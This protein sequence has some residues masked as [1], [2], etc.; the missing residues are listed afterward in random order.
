MTL[1][2]GLPDRQQI[3][4]LSART[5]LEI[6]AVLFN[7]DEPFTFTSG[8]KSPVYIDCR[9]IIAFPR[10]RRLL[11]D[12]AL[13]NLVREIGVESIDCIAGGETAGIPF[14][15][16]LADRLDLPMCYVRKEPKG[17]G[18][19]AQIEGDLAEGARTLLVE[20]LTTDG[21]SKVRFVEALRKA[22]AEVNDTFV[23]FH[24]GIF[25]ASLD[26]MAELQL[27][28]HSLTTWWDV[29]K[30]ARDDKWLPSK[31]VQV[32]EDYLKNPVGWSDAHGGKKD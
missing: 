17:F 29:L 3:A 26:T 1:I 27:R 11:M 15:A 9:K 32:V 8:K 28:L 16:W 14:A 19:M 23:I 6:E 13:A 20:D 25:D 2:A 18:R 12:F 5:L 10:A 4:E 24:Y 31:T 21:G 22:G 30:V 7:A